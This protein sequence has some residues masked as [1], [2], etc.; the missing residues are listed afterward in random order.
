MATA[1]L[2]LLQA[3]PRAVSLT[4]PKASRR[5]DLPPSSAAPLSQTGDPSKAWGARPR[6]LEV[7]QADVALIPSVKPMT[8]F[9][10]CS[11]S[12]QGAPSAWGSESGLGRNPNP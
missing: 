7:S 3:Q 5:R 4:R 10:L 12:R 6:D 1:H 9:F 2:R 8:V 11:R